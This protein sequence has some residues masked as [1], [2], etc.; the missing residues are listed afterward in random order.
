MSHEACFCSKYNGCAPH[1]YSDSFYVC[2]LCQLI[3]DYCPYYLEKSI[4][5]DPIK[6]IK[7][8]SDIFNR[9]KKIGQ[10]GGE[11]AVCCLRGYHDYRTYRGGLSSPYTIFDVVSPND[12]F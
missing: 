12:M 11:R 4:N 7:A 5:K 8:A 2:E 1:Y 3:T 10:I 9:R 6:H